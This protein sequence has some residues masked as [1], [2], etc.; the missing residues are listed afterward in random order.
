MIFDIALF[1]AGTLVILLVSFS[2][3][4]K[5]ISFSRFLKE[6]LA[7][8]AVVS[9]SLI[10]VIKLL[11]L[12]RSFEQLD[13][14]QD[15]VS[16]TQFWIKIFVNLRPLLFGILL[17]IGFMPFEKRAGKTASDAAVSRSGA[18]SQKPDSNGKVS[19]ELPK[20]D[21]TNAASGEPAEP[22]ATSQETPTT[23]HAS[24]KPDES[25][26]APRAVPQNPV[27][28]EKQNPDAIAPEASPVSPAAT[29]SRREIEVA[30]LAA[31]GWTN[32]QIA[33]HL[34]IS[35]ATV[36]RHLATIFEKLG[37]N[38]RRELAGKL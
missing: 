17:R 3:H 9:G 38:S 16:F 29:L 14:S 35:V 4:D 25:P 1:C 27:P 32:T 18:A 15:A 8:C 22:S 21:A 7:G 20:L 30:R 33:E 26:T 6:R 13:L 10:T 12:G 5:K 19:G 34:F 11:V 23:P 36:K 31:A 28:T 37:I 2:A 24:L